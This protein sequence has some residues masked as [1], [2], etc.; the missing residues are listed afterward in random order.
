[1]A[2]VRVAAPC[3]LC[4]VN[5]RAVR[6]SNRVQ[7]AESGGF[8]RSRALYRVLVV[9]S[10]FRSCSGASDTTAK[11]TPNPAI[12][13]QRVKLCYDSKPSARHPPVRPYTARL[14]FCFEEAV[15]WHSRRPTWAWCG[16]AALTISACGS[17]EAEVQKH[18]QKVAS[19]RA[20][21]V[22]IT[23]AWVQGD[24]TGTYAE[25]ALAQTFQLVEQERAAV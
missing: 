13:P 2:S 11:R 4:G 3:V 19:L 18:A 1:M 15:Y 21:T 14:G 8:N 16:M 20:T 10:S 6:S 22:S 7:A 5:L 23:E 25:V 24:V 9:W 12:A 17:P